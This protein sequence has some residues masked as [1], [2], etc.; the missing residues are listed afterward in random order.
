MAIGDAFS[1]DALTPYDWAHFGHLCNLPFRPVAH[2]LEA[3]TGQ[4][5]AV[6]DAFL[7]DMTRDSVP[8]EVARCFQQ[9]VLTTCARQRAHVGQIARFKR[10][11]FH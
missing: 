8:V 6:M 11:D 10:A 2:E 1:E 4:V 3:M 7:A 5:V 9:L